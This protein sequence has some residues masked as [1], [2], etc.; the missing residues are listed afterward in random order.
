[1]KTLA[2]T[3]FYLLHTI[4]CWFKSKYEYIK[5]KLSLVQSTSFNNE[6]T[7]NQSNAVFYCLTLLSYTIIMMMMMMINIVAY[8]S[9]QFLLLKK[10]KFLTNY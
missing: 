7:F 5:N 2:F 8:R 6:L 9:T 4:N 1:M 3:G 10:T